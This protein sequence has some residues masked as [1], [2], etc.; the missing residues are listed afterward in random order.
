MV[1]GLAGVLQIL[2]QCG[3]CLLRARKV[4]TL[5]RTLERLEILSNLARGA[6]LTAGIGTLRQARHVLLESRKGLLSGGEISRL[7]RVL[8]RFEVLCALPEANGLGSGLITI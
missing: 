8:Q 2:C 4:A 6:G 1:V 5:Q 7:Q 3:K